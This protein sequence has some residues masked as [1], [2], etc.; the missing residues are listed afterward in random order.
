[1]KPSSA[2]ALEVVEVAAVAG[3]A[4]HHPGRV[5]AL[6]VA[7]QR[8]H[9]QAGLGTGVGVH[10]DRCSG[11]AVRPGHGPHHPGHP[12][13]H[14]LVVDGAL[15]ERRLDSCAR[16]ALCDVGDEHVHHRVGHVHTERRRQGRA[17][18]EEEERHLVVGVAARGRDDVELGYLLG[19][20]LDARDVPAQAHDGRVGDAADPLGGKGLQ[21]ADGVGHPVVLTAPFGRV[22]LLHVGVEN[23]DVL[24]HVGRPEVGGVDR[25]PDALNGCHVPTPSGLRRKPYVSRWFR[26]RR[27]RPARLLRVRRMATRRIEVRAPSWLPWERCHSRGSSAPG[28]LK[29]PRSSRRSMRSSCET[30]SQGATLHSLHG[31]SAS[32]TQK[33]LSVP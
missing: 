24:V 33:H 16:D 7:Q 2:S 19:D 20:A 21:L 12:V 4:Q 17:P 22:V 11:V 3:V 25:T 14:A 13:G 8:L 31:S 30:G 5:D 26:A 18:V 29:P 9:V 15:E 28:M 1:M 6:L 23:K 32:A 10:G 27:N